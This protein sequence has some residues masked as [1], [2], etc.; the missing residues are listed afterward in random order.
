MSIVD[1]IV[2]LYAPHLCVSCGREGAVLCQVCIENLRPADE[3]CYRCAADSP[4]NMTCTKCCPY[5]PLV[6]VHALTDYD[7]PARNVLS[8]MK[9]ERALSAA[10]EI[11][12]LMADR[13][14]SAIADDVVIVPVPTARSRVRSRGYDHSVVVA[15]ALARQCGVSFA[16]PIERRGSKQQKGSDRS[17]RIKQLSG[18]YELRRSQG[19]KGRRV[20]VVDDVVTTGATLEEVGRILKAG[21]AEVVGAVVFARA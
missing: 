16:Q 14:G 3:K 19:I 10:H 9:S 7:G 2:S 11:A 5:S 13:F 15:R 20:L 12:S 1:R 6:G 21:G 8:K 17:Q 18:A 4:R